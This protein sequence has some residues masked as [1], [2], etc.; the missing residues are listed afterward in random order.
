MVEAKTPLVDV[1]RHRDELQPHQPADKLLGGHQQLVGAGRGGFPGLDPGRQVVEKPFQLRL[2]KGIDPG[3]GAD[4]G[5]EGAN[6][7]AVGVIPPFGNLPRLAR[8]AEQGF[9]RLDLRRHRAIEWRRFHA[10]EHG[11]RL[12]FERI[13]GTRSQQRF[14][15]LTARVV[16]EAGEIADQI[17][18][19]RG[20]L[21]PVILGRNVEELLLLLPPRVDRAPR[22]FLALRRAELAAGYGLELALVMLPPAAAGRHPRHQVSLG[23]GP[24]LSLPKCRTRMVRNTGTA[25]SGLGNEIWQQTGRCRRVWQRG[26]KD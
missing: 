20:T 13:E 22:R 21:Q 8:R 11:G 12:G 18:D 6:S 23:H 10:G 17:A 2:V 15:R 9:P 16:V 1:A 7:P 3:A 24:P 26:R 4:P 14:H 5:H 19:A 25:S